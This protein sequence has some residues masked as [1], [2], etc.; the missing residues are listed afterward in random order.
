VQELGDLPDGTSREGVELVLKRRLPISGRVVWAD[1]RPAVG[2]TVA[3]VHED[4]SAWGKSFGTGEVE[5]ENDGRFQITEVGTAPISLTA[6]MKPTLTRRSSPGSASGAKVQ[7]DQSPWVAFLAGVEAGTENVV[8]TL[9]PGVSIQGRVL[10]EAGQPIPTFTVRA[11]PVRTH[12]DMFVSD[13][14]RCMSTGS[15]GAF[16]LVGLRAGSWQL[17]AN[18]PG[19][20]DAPRRAFTIPGDGRPID[21]ILRRPATLSGVVVDASGRPVSSAKVSVGTRDPLSPGTYS[22][23]SSN[24]DRTDADGRFNIT[25]VSP[26]SLVVTASSRGWSDSEWMPIEVQSGQVVSG[27]TITLRPAR[28]PAESK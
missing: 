4:I 22:F 23:S 3:Y 28:E 11:D 1:G 2:C 15:N 20:A 9:G 5:T 8:L 7:L 12:E 16:E 18:A 17:T 19:Y 21:L 25:K 10:D 26:G 27:L 24:E 6:R 14:P 13:G